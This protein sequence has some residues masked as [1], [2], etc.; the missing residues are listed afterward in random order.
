MEIAIIISKKDLASLNIKKNLLNHFVL[1]SK[2]FDGNKVYF[3]KKTKIYTF[4][5]DSLY[6]DV[7]Q[8]SE[9]III[10]ASRHCSVNKIPCFTCHATG[11]WNDAKYG[12]INNK[13]SL[14]SS[15][16]LR[17]VLFLLNN[18]KNEYNLNN[19]NIFQEI[20]HHGPLVKK[21]SF[22]IEIG[23][24]ENE[25]NNNLYGK[26]VSEVIIKLIDQLSLYNS[27]NDFV[28]DYKNNNSN[29]KSAIALG[30]LHNM[31]NF[32]KLIFSKNIAIS[33]ACPK[34]SLDY[35]N[36]TLFN[37]SINKTVEK[38]DL[39]ILDWKSLKNKEDLIQLLNKNKKEWKKIN[40][41]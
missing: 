1:N 10:F 12:G 5:N 20:T 39:F 32:M 6:S 37:E 14:T 23:S 33:H 21:P 25:W 15:F 24:T 4:N 13:L 41:I 38:I 28:L 22:F 18:K 2:I 16:L 29:L 35:F 3:Y 27:F 31:Q 26:I 30:G 34:N 8:F 11:N 40:Q 9:D 7:N 19:I 17:E 36:E